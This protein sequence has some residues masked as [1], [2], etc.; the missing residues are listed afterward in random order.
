MIGQDPQKPSET[1]GRRTGDTIA[2]PG[3]YQAR[4]IAE[5]FVVQRYWHSRKLE[6]IRRVCPPRGD[7]R[8]LDVGCGSGVVSNFL[9][10]LARSVDAVDG[11][12]AALEYARRNAAGCNMKFHLGLVDEIDLP[13]GSFDRIYCLEVIEHV[14]PDQ[15]VKLLRLLGVLLAPDGRLLVTTPN[16]G[17]L[18]PVIEWTMDRLRLAP[19]MEQDQHV[20]H[21][22]AGSLRRL[23]EQSGLTVVDL[24]RFCGAAPFLSVLSWKLAAAVDG[25]ERRLDCPWG[26]LLYAVGAN[27]AEGGDHG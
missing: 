21:L 11:S 6:L 24:G 20:T 10:G 5:G 27:A 14:F 25:L 4:A 3:D 1:T 9:A 15:I 26:N 12:P 22:D 19:R 23:L 18:W 13:P 16:Y 7:S 8:A 2:I 17:S